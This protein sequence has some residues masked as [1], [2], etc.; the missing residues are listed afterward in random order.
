MAT[1][2]Q[3]NTSGIRRQTDA[4][5]K[6]RY[7]YTL[8]PHTDTQLPRCQH[9][10]SL[11]QRILSPRLQKVVVEIH[12]Y[13]AAVDT[14]EVHVTCSTRARCHDALRQVKAF[15][16]RHLI[17]TGDYSVTKKRQKDG[18]RQPPQPVGHQEATTMQQR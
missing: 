1:D 12:D 14:A 9:R 5:S 15:D 8:T 16:G 10:Y 2:M 11:R 4:D 17:V 6:Y 13:T 18:P 7:H 3:L